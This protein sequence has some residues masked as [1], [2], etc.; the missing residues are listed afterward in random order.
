MTDELPDQLLVAPT[1][2][3]KS[4]ETRMKD[5]AACRKLVR[6]LMTEDEPRSWRRAVTKGCYDG[7]PPMSRV[8]P[9]YSWTCNLNF[10]EMEGLMD[11]ARIPYY[12][13]FSGVEYYTLFKT[14]YQRENPDNER[15]NK[16]V[17]EE[18]TRMLNRWKQFRWHM[19]ASEF[20]MLF[21]GWGPLMFENQ[22]DWRFTSVP[23][24][25]IKV[26]QGAYSCVDERLPYL[27]ILRD[28]RIHELWNKI[29][30]PES[31][32]ATGW[33]VDA[34]KEAI[35]RAGNR[36]NSTNNNWEYWQQ[37]LRNADYC[38]SFSEA[39]IVPCAMVLVQEAAKGGKR[40]KISS[41]TVT[42]DE[43]SSKEGGG[44]E[45]LCSQPN[46]YDEYHEAIIVCFQ[47]TGDGTWHS[48]RGIAL[49]S[50][51]HIEVSSNID[52]L[53]FPNHPWHGFH[54]GQ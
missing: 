24:R 19:R 23:A 52:R 13:L 21:E 20:E 33:N 44:Y 1:A 11:S 3:T 10:G 48:V 22:T 25:C 31:A 47:N 9:G 43:I 2:L 53:Q 45:Y 30:D 14:G 26:P 38:A 5:A 12:A 17:C 35:C 18:W 28:Y 50:F 29:S 6:Q 41:F 42:V 51:K 49:K 36:K 40:G 8:P 46:Q 54:G 4:S 37:R 15:W 39:D 7:N 16:I 34:V 27:V 32:T